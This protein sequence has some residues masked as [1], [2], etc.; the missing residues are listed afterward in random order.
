[1]TWWHG[2]QLPYHCPSQGWVLWSC[3]PRY[4]ALFLTI[5]VSLSGRESPF[6][7]LIVPRAGTCQPGGGSRQTWKYVKGSIYVRAMEVTGNVISQTPLG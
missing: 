4:P 3:A 6:P 1:M 2:Q 5:S 7:C